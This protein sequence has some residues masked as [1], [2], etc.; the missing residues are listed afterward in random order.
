[1]TNAVDSWS[2]EM[3]AQAVCKLLR[4]SRRRQKLTQ[5]Q[6]AARTGGLISKA[7][8]ANYETGHRSLRIDVLWVIAHALGESMSSIV[9]S[10]ERGLTASHES[11]AGTPVSI[12]LDTLSVSRDPRLTAVRRWVDLQHRPHNGQGGVIVLDQGAVEALSSLMGVS[13]AECRSILSG[14]SGSTFAELPEHHLPDPRAAEIARER[15]RAY[16][17]T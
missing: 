14:V 3:F 12:D 7:A 10:A 11:D 17:L 1:M 15:A 4:E 6:V 13:Q 8:L 9:A 2:K 16:Q 5:A